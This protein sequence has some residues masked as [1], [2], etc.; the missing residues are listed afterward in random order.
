MSPPIAGFPFVLYV[1]V[2]PVDRLCAAENVIELPPLPL[3]GS[4][5]EPALNVPS[6]AAGGDWPWVASNVIVPL[7]E[8]ML[9]PALTVNETLGFIVAE[10][11]KFPTWSRIPIVVLVV[12]ASESERPS[13]WPLTSPCVRMTEPLPP[14]DAVVFGVPCEV[15]LES[16]ID[17][18]PPP[19]SFMPASA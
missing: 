4:T 17:R 2:L 7:C 15:A 10:A 5:W 11:E 9:E 6:D 8:V 18:A 19:A 16:P 13:A 3:L 12:L 1:I 14:T